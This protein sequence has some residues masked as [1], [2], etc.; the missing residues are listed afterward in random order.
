MYSQL[1]LGFY[2]QC[3]AVIRNLAF[4]I[5]IPLEKKQDLTFIN[6]ICLYSPLNIFVSLHRS[7]V[8]KCCLYVSEMSYKLKMSA[9]LKVN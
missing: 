5:V 7:Y 4:I 2:C 1:V 3:K 6:N 8:N 9:Y